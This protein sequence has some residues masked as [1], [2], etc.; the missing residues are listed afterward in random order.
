MIKISLSQTTLTTLHTALTLLHTA[1]DWSHCTHHWRHCTQLWSHCTHRWPHCSCTQ[2]WPHCTPRHIAYTA[3]RIALVFLTLGLNVTCVDRGQHRWPHLYLIIIMYSLVSISSLFL[4][5]SGSILW[6]TEM[7]YL[8]LG[9]VAFACPPKLP[10][11]VYENQDNLS[12]ESDYRKPA[13]FSC[14][15]CKCEH[16]V[17]ICLTNWEWH[18]I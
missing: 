17:I 6:H 11:L 14:Y 15:V 13:S 8:V 4:M 18:F 12:F 3:D 1:L 16:R 5:Y 2:R 9:L 10:E 7:N